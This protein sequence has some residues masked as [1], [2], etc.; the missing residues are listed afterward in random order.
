VDFDQELWQT[1][2]RVRSRE[3]AGLEMI[4]REYRL[5]HVRDSFYRIVE[6]RAGS[7]E[8]TEMNGQEQ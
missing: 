6:R 5:E 1:G 7:T 8:R 2:A 4:K 3:A